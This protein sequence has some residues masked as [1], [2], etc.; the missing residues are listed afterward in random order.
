MTIYKAANL[1]FCYGVKR[2]IS[3]ARGNYRK[4]V[5]TLG[6]LIHN[7]VIV[8]AL[9]REG[10]KAVSDVDE[11]VGGTLVIRSH[12]APAESIE[13]AKKAGLDIVDATCPFVQKTRKI[14]S[15][16]Y[17]DGYKIVI[18]GKKDHPEVIGINSLCEYS[19]FIAD[20]NFDV[21]VLDGYEKVCVVAQTTA[22]AQKYSNC[23]SGSI[24][25]A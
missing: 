18:F 10:I 4:P 11:A 2:S 25:F 19:A 22:S 16:K 1:G 13:K 24:Q 23:I 21:S 12:G 9:E 20:E 3:L 17:A 14:V 8:N 6:E 15:E 5:Y 7:S